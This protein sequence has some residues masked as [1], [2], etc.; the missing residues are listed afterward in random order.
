MQRF[1]VTLLLSFLGALGQVGS[2]SAAPPARTPGPLPGLPA[3]LPPPPPV[4][5]L[6]FL[7]ERFRDDGERTIGVLALEPKDDPR[8]VAIAEVLRAALAIQR[9]LNPEYLTARPGFLD[10]SAVFPTAAERAD[11]AASRASIPPRVAAIPV[12]L[13]VGGELAPPAAPGGPRQVLLWLMD[14]KTGGLWWG[15][16]PLDLPGVRAPRFLLLHLLADAGLA[17]RETERS[18]MLWIEDLDDASLATFGALIARGEQPAW[19]ALAPW[20]FT[21]TRYALEH[22]PMLD[23]LEACAKERLALFD[24]VMS[25]NPR[26]KTNVD[27]LSCALAGVD[28]DGLL[29]Q[30]TSNCQVSQKALA[31]IASLRDTNMTGL[32]AGLG[33]LYR[34]ETC[35]DQSGILEET[36]LKAKDLLVRSGLLLELGLANQIAG[37][38]DAAVRVFTRVRDEYRSRGIGL[39]M[40]DSAARRGGRAAAGRSRAHARGQHR[41]EG[42]GPGDHRACPGLRRSGHGGAGAELARAREPGRGTP[43]RGARAVRRGARAFQGDRR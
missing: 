27:I 32:V 19:E 5:N 41:R 9:E 36:A 40:S 6:D 33:G 25:L 34:G 26:G 4:P 11:F 13:L 17:P 21:A 15:R 16:A 14:R 8:G 38:D 7:P 35:G 23:P 29:R 1:V 28:I 42:V 24:R 37:H 20:S 39:R 2:G 18:D 31:S 43:G 3:M 10:S 30:A 12:R 22:L